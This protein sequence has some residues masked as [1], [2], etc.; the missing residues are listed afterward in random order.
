M[1]GRIPAEVAALA[2]K[3]RGMGVADVELNDMDVAGGV[4]VTPEVEMMMPRT[5]SAIKV[6]TLTG[7]D[8]TIDIDH[9]VGAMKE[10]IQQEEG[11]PPEQQRL[12][13][14]GKQLADH[15]TA[16]VYGLKP[17]VVLHLVLALKGGGSIRI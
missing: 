8:I 17:R 4:Y 7:K 11:I 6:K 9:G 14:G 2:E 1:H 10:R 16:R 5:S 12:I 13:F 3:L 15:K